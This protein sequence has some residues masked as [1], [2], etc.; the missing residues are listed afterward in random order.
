MP[1]RTCSE[2][3]CSQPVNCRGMCRR[4][5]MRWRRTNDTQAR[6]CDAAGCGKPHYARGWCNTHYARVWA[7]GTI[8]PPLWESWTETDRKPCK[9]CGE[10]KT[11]DEFSPNAAGFLGRNARCRPCFNVYQNNGPRLARIRRRWGTAGVEIEE[12]RRRGAGCDVCGEVTDPMHLDHDHATDEAR[13]LLCRWCNLA[14][15]HV[16]DDVAKLR[17]LA[18][19]LERATAH[20]RSA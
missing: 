12:R 18:D 14:L 5:Y 4:H 20:V 3:S 11:V 17:A 9:M 19:Y 7:T 10:V 2:S 13:G 16:Q 6:R 15:G 8:E 1:D